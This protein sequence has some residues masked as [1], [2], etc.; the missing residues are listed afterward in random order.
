MAGLREY[1]RTWMTPD[2]HKDSPTFGT[3]FLKKCAPFDLGSWIERSIISNLNIIICKV[4]V[5]SCKHYKL[6]HI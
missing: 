2:P 3:D 5:T 6:F 4:S 1:E